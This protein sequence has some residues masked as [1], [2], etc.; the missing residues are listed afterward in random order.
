MAGNSGSGS[1][2]SKGSRGKFSR[3]SVVVKEEGN[4]RG[5]ESQGESPSTDSG[6]IPSPGMNSAMS[7]TGS[8]SEGVSASFS[9]D[10]EAGGNNTLDLD[11]L[12]HAQFG[13]KKRGLWSVLCP[14]FAQDQSIRYKSN[15]LETSASGGM[16][17]STRGLKQVLCPWFDKGSQQ[18]A[19]FMM[20]M[21]LL[22]RLRHPYITTV[23]GAVISPVRLVNENRC[24]N[25]EESRSFLLLR[26]RFDVARRD[27]C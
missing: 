3:G 27:E 24:L 13:D 23:M 26:F 1:K 4:S 6:S 5:I 10:I 21:R 20:E 8:H 15:I 25:C 14:W 7:T 16:S 2:G 17:G 11:F 12:G 19:E 22:S 18:K 9:N